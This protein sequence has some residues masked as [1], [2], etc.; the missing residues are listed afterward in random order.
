MDA[1]LE[2]KGPN[3]GEMEPVAV[4]QEV[5]KEEAAVKANQRSGMMES[6]LRAQSNSGSPKKMA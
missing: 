1:C 5:H 3:S 2:S 4:H 6:T